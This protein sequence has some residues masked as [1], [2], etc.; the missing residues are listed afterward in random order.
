[1]PRKWNYHSNRE[2]IVYIEFERSELVQTYIDGH[3]VWL[4]FSIPVACVHLDVWRIGGGKV[5]EVGII[6]IDSKTGLEASPFALPYS[7]I[8]KCFRLVGLSLTDNTIGQ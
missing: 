5:Y 3:I 8:S 6:A 7:V 4:E 1:M 2:F